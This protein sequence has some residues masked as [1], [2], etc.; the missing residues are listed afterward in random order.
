[1]SVGVRGSTAIGNDGT[2][3]FGA[4]NLYALRPDGSQKWTVAL[5]NAPWSTPAIGLDGTIYVVAS[6]V[7]YAVTPDGMPKWQHVIDEH[8]GGAILSPSIGADGTIYVGSFSYR[9]FYAIN[10]GGSEKWTFPLSAA[11]VDSAAIAADGTVYLGDGY[12]LYALANG[13]AIWQTSLQASGPAVIGRDGTIFVANSDLSLYSLTPGG[14]TNWHVAPWSIPALPTTPAVDSAG[15]SYYCVSN[16]LLAVGP[17]GGVRWVF[18]SGYDVSYYVTST[19]PAIGPDGTI[20]AAFG[21]KL[22]ALAGT[23]GLGN[24]PWPMYHQN[25]RHTGKVERPSL[26]APQKR[27]DGN[28]GVEVYAQLGDPFTLQA[29]TNLNT[30][31]SLTSFVATTVPMDVVDWSATN[32]PL[33]FYRASSP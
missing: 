26:K 31:T 20:Y 32:F 21:S 29:S 6:G 22:F 27:T 13:R 7:L 4:D 10:P 2:I 19:S 9:T 8:T 24:A 23:N 1:V 11:S 3:Y 14:Q 28:V 18:K 5:T 15:V 16:A 25:A 12:H 17:E 33:R 30:W